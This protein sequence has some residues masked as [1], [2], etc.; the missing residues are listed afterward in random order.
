M[1]RDAFQSADLLIPDGISI[2]LSARLLHGARVSRVPG[3]DL[4][5][6]I[7]AMAARLK[8]GVFVYGAQEEINRKA[9]E[10]LKILYPGLDIVG[11]SHG[12]VKEQA[13][14]DLIDLINLSGAEILFLALGSPNQEKWYAAHCRELYNI[15]I[16]Q[17]IGGT[18]DVIAGTVQRAPKIWQRCNAEWLYRLLQDPKRIKRQKVLPLFA[19]KVLS[20]KLHTIL[21]G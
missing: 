9:A 13:M 4:M 6:R 17:G 20:L 15:K 3:V 8:L 1:L 14:S 12:Y 5:H 7:C 11:R 16:C 10:R 19:L 2:V 18:L 21:G